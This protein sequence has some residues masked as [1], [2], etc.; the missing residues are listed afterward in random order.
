MMLDTSL[1]TSKKCSFAHKRTNH[2]NRWLSEHPDHPSAGPQHNFVLTGNMSNAS[3]S[4]GS[5]VL[6]AASI[7][8]EETIHESDDPSASLL[9]TNNNV[10]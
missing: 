9:G 10:M 1:S 6:P 8:P 4:E 3:R 5:T 7:V 2:P